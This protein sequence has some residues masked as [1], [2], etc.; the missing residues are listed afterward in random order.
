MAVTLQ[1]SLAAEPQSN[2]N[3]A[4]GITF[5]QFDLP[6]GNQ[7]ILGSPHEQGTVIPLALRPTSVDSPK[8]SLNSAISAVKDLQARDG[9][10]TKLLARH[11]TLLFR[12]LPIHNAE[13]FSRFAHAFGYK[14]HEIIGIVVNRPM[15][16]PN[17]APANE[18]PKEVLIYSHN[19]SPQVRMLSFSL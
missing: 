2:N 4:T 15:L 1:A 16:A 5:E 11:G 8:V 13:D 7:R 10:L 19:E 6:P 12:G 17:V 14:P 9:I 3:A 18:A